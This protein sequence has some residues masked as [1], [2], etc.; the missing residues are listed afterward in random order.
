MP[1]LTRKIGNDEVSAIGLGVMRVSVFYGTPDS[2]EERFKVN[3]S[4]AI[5]SAIDAS[6]TQLLDAALLEGSTFWDTAAH[7]GDNEEFIGR[8]WVF[9][10]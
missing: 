5:Y 1:R 10:N 9:N 3:L 6:E 8:W 4:T 2:D 7:Y